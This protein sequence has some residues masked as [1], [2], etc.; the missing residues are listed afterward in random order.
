VAG[1][2]GSIE[3]SSTE[4]IYLD[5]T[6]LAPAGGPTGAGGTLTVAA[7]APAYLLHTSSA[8]PATVFIPDPLRVPFDIVISQD[9][10][11][12]LLAGGLQP[13]DPSF[14]NTPGAI[15]SVQL[16]AAQIA[17]GGFGNVALLAT[18]SVLFNGDAT[19][20][21]SQSIQIAAG[22]IGMT[23]GSGQAT[24]AAPYVLLRGSGISLPSNFATTVTEAGTILTQTFVY[25]GATA[26]SNYSQLP[27]CLSGATA[28]TSANFTVQA[29]PTSRF[30][31]I[32]QPVAASSRRLRWRWTNPASTPST[33]SAAA[34]SVSC[35]RG[36]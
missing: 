17:A 5:G 33:W 24:I 16:S 21:A 6:L 10:Q 35:P 36:R 30:H 18:D 8:P 13:G 20:S 12:S 23:Q 31:S 7:A 14:A 26:A 9:T 4:G 27:P 34:T 29:A 32:C 19:L 22:A 2:G 28:C 3:V 1:N 11:P 25:T 15:G